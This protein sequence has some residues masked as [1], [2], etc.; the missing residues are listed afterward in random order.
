MALSTQ[1]WCERRPRRG[2]ASEREKN[3]THR[4][5]L[6][7]GERG[8]ERTRLNERGRK[9]NSPGS[10]ENVY[11]M[12]ILLHRTSLHADHSCGWVSRC[13]NTSLIHN[14]AKSFH[15]RTLYDHSDV[16]MVK[17]TIRDPGVT[18]SFIIFTRAG[19]NVILRIR[20]GWYWCKIQDWTSE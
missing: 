16:V 6:L 20:N 13:Q 15:G 3:N 1:S 18:L 10:T 12:W 7:Q 11:C 19:T 5:K 14:T 4:H 8:R 9:E 17:H 2:D